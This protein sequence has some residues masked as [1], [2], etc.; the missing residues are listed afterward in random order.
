MQQLM[1]KIAHLEASQVGDV[2][3]GVLKRY[4]ELFPDW[5]ISTISLDKRG[6]RYEQLSRV[7]SLL[8]S[9]KDPQ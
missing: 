7:I 2:L 1:E 9:M 8:E 4:G 3:K 6:D 5:D